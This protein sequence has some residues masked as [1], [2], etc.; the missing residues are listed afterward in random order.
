MTFPNGDGP[1]LLPAK[2]FKVWTRL[3]DRFL[4]EPSPAIGSNAYVAP[5]IQPVTD[6]DRLLQALDI[7]S[8]TI[9]VT[10]AIGFVVATVTQGQRWT[11][12]FWRSRV[13]SGTW[14]HNGFS[15]VSPAGVSMTLHS[16]ATSSQAEL[17]ELSQP[18]VLD[19]GWQLQVNV[20][21]Y[22]SQGDL[23]TNLLILR[24]DAF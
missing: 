8:S 11:V 9:D 6:A 15:I 7:E 24:E 3:Y 13:S 12:S 17:W 23:I 20:N 10:S 1:V 22:T 21:G 16:Y 19:E 14:T 4:L 5:V 2:Q 18:L